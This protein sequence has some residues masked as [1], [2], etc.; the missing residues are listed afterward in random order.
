MERVGVVTRQDSYDPD[1]LVGSNKGSHYWRRSRVCEV[2]LGITC[3]G[4]FSERS[5][6]EKLS[7]AGLRH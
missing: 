4:V 7:K 1:S 2:S 3:L 5:L 6:V